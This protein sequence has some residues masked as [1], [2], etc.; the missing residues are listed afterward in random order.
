MLIEDI[1]HHAFIFI[2]QADRFL[3]F[4]AI[5]LDTWVQNTW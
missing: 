1:L 5:P 3:K 4:E 2:Y